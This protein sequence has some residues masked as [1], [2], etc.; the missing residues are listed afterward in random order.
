MTEP[1]FSNQEACCPA[2]IVAFGNN[3]PDMTKSAAYDTAR[4]EFYR[5]RLQEDIQR[6]VAAEEAAAYGAEFDHHTWK[7]YE[8]GRGGGRA[9]RQ[10]GCL[11]PGNI[12]GPDQR[13]SALSGAPDLGETT[14]S[15][16][17][18]AE[19]TEVRSPCET[20]HSVRA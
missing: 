19:E 15:S 17:I 1:A 16:E 8:D 5:L 12:S 18:G 13:K 2:T 7:S 9:V 20:C 11:G 10:P 3:V 4:R 6:R 14:E